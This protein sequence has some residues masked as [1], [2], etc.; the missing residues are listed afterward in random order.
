MYDQKSRAEIMKTK[1]GKTV[2]V[3]DTVFRPFAGCVA[4]YKVKDFFTNEIAAHYHSTMA[5]AA[6]QLVAEI[7]CE[8]A[9]LRISRAVYVEMARK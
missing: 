7:D 1:D 2:K 4:D 3:G 5:S 8:I 9:R 6:A